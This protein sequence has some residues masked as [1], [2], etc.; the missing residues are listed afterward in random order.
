MIAME[1]VIKRGIS[2]LAALILAVSLTAT[3]TPRAQAADA[4]VYLPDPHEF[5]E[6]DHWDLLAGKRGNT[7]IYVAFVKKNGTFVRAAGGLDDYLRSSQPGQR[8][9][10]DLGGAMPNFPAAT[11]GL[12]A[13]ADGT[14]WAYVRQAGRWREAKIGSSFDV[15][16]GAITVTERMTQSQADAMARELN[17][18]IGQTQGAAGRRPARPMSNPGPET[19]RSDPWYQDHVLHCPDGHSFPRDDKPEDWR[20]QTLNMVAACAAVAKLPISDTTPPRFVPLADNDLIKH[21]DETTALA[22]GDKAVVAQT[23]DLQKIWAKADQDNLDGK[24]GQWVK[25]QTAARLSM[26]GI[27]LGMAVPYLAAVLVGIFL[28]AMLSR[29]RNAGPT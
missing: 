20:P 2:C 25:F 1:T 13:A 12:F 29:R 28:A 9:F 5:R 7:D 22:P 21:L 23:P 15:P 3:I 27:L 6:G 16:G 10:T 26:W 18:R 14:L 4:T 17:R 24:H 11:E 19:P 8:N